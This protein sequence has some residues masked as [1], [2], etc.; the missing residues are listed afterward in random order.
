MRSKDIDRLI[1]KLSRKA[2]QDIRH[3]RIQAIDRQ[4]SRLY[5]SPFT[6]QNRIVFLEAIR[7]GI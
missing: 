2:K 6:N 4:L 3:K 5:T 7:K 1:G